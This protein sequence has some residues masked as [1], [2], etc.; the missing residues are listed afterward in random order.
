MA[1]R[2]TSRLLTSAGVA[3]T[4]ALASLGFVGL[5]SAEDGAAEG[6]TLFQLAERH[7]GD[8]GA[9]QTTV[10]QG[11]EGAEEILYSSS[12][13][14]TWGDEVAWFD[15]QDGTWH[16]AH[17][18]DNVFEFDQGFDDDDSFS[19][20]F[21]LVVSTADGRGLGF[22]SL[23]DGVLRSDVQGLLSR[24][25]L[26]FRF[27]LEG[28]TWDP[29]PVC[30][31]EAALRAGVMVPSSFAVVDPCLAHTEEPVQV[32]ATAAE[33]DG[34]PVARFTLTLEQAVVTVDYN[35]AIPEA[36][37]LERRGGD[38]AGHSFRT[39][40]TLTG[41]EAGM[42]PWDTG[43]VLPE[44]VALPAVTLAPR[45][46]WGADD[47]DID[48][49]FPASAAWARAMDDLSNTEL[50]AYMG[51][52]PDAIA[53][54]ADYQQGQHGN[55]TVRQWNFHLTDG[56]AEFLL[57]SQQEVAPA[58]AAATDYLGLPTL[59]LPMT[60]LYD[61]SGAP[62]DLQGC[63]FDP[64]TQLPTVQSM[65]ARWEATT[66]VSGAEPAWSLGCGY[67]EDFVRAGTTRMDVSAYRLADQ[68]TGSPLT[69]DG[70]ANFLH[71]DA[72]GDVFGLAIETLNVAFSTQ[73]GPPSTAPVE[74]SASMTSAPA[75]VLSLAGLAWLPPS[76]GQASGAAAASLL[77][78]ILYWL[79]P[80]LKAGP[81]ALFSRTTTS[82]LLD[83]PLR[84]Q[85]A[86]LVEAQPGIHY[87]AILR[88]VGGGKGA[89]E[90]HLRK[91]TQAG[92][93]LKH[94]GTGFTCFFPAG[95]NR[96]DREAASVLKAEGARK[97]L[98]AIQGQ[99]GSSN[100][101]VAQATGLDPGTVHYH[102]HRLAGSGLVDLQREGRTLRLHAR[103]AATKA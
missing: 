48:H 44:P 10:Y 5:A 55:R 9:V 50:Q 33:L 63:D 51:E 27:L 103:E 16:A 28:L 61:S 53:R 49:P 37:R 79:W 87:Q 6:A 102:V 54:S 8:R 25:Q 19:S 75:P 86:D 85:I 93:L 77:A 56:A 58:G 67:D 70:A 98:A 97:I 17:I 1:N 59:P 29:Q 82:R 57:V 7:G 35:A 45:L 4:L 84:R 78:G 71:A 18:Q 81:L 21:G 39:V 62:L 72:R 60:T 12:L 46:P 89:V 65:L 92:V 64:S 91:L 99:P 66:G 68:L 83:H 52:H 80:V 100:I 88:V 26:E 3:A 69:M 90:H 20:Q 101:Q 2:L 94:Q 31:L 34:I 15:G 95:T 74:A 43:I 14:F 24:S 40:S 13:H 96:R 30:G 23:H 47:S 38:G 32:V 42:Q 11:P 41:F 76:T 22:T 73:T 36:L